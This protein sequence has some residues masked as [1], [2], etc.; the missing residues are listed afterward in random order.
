MLIIVHSLADETAVV[1]NI[2]KCITHFEELI[3][4]IMLYYVT[5]THAHTVYV[6]IT[7]NC[8]YKMCTC[9]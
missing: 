1:G 2:F 5:N 7:F 4:Y 9:N 6:S 8:V 3:S